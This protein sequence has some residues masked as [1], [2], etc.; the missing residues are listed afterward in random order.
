VRREK[1]LA[2]SDKKLEIS[3]ETGKMGFGL[4]FWVLKKVL[5]YGIH[6]CIYF[7]FFDEKKVTKKNQVRIKIS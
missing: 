5:K 1:K 3:L 2:P 6:S 4:G 7:L